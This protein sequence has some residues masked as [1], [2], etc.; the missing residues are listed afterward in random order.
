MRPLDGLVRAF[1]V[2]LAM[3]VAIPVEEVG[4]K[5]C[6]HHN[7]FSHGKY[8]RIAGEEKEE[9]EKVCSGRIIFRRRHCSAISIVS[10]I[11][12]HLLLKA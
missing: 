11:E 12:V 3:A 7:Q 1:R 8:T 10:S 5:F 4:S 2:A 9:K 6:L